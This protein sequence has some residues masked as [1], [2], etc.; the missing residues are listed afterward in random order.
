MTGS[1]SIAIGQGAQVS[2]IDSIGIGVSSNV[3][4]NN[5]GAFGD[6]NIVTG[7]GSYVVGNNNI[8]AANN[9]FVLGSFVIMTA[10]MTD[11][12][13]IGYGSSVTNANDVA[14]GARSATA[15]PHTGSYDITGGT[16]FATSDVNGVVSVGAPGLERQIQNVAAGVVSAS[17]SD[18]INGSQLYSVAT[19]GNLTGTTVANALGGGSTYSPATGVSAPSYTV[20]STPY[21][22][23][24]SAVTG[25]QTG[26]PVQYSTTTNPTVANGY[27]PS[28]NETLVGAAPG[29]VTLSNVAAGVAPTDAVNVSQLTSQN[30]TLIAA[31]LNFADATG[32]SVHENLGGTISVIGSTAPVGGVGAAF[33]SSGSATAGAYSAQNVQTVVNPATGQ[34]QVQIAANPNFTSV[35]TGNTVVNNAGVTVNGGTNGTVSLTNTGLNNGNN[36]ITNVAAG[37][38]QTDAVNV[39]QLDAVSTTASKGW[40]V[41]TAASGTGTVYGTSVANV[42]PGATQTVTAGNNIAITQ[43]GTGLTI[44]TN[45]NLVSTSLTTTD[46]TGNTT[47]TTGTG[48]TITDGTGNTTTTT[49]TGVTITPAGGGSPVSLT[50]TGLNNGNNTI[51]NVAAGVNQTDAV[52]V[53]QL[54]AVSTTASKGWNVT[55]AASGTGTVY[56]TSVANVAPGATQ[57][58]TAGNNIAITQNGTG[59]TIATN[60]NL[61]STS[62]TIQGGNSGIGIDMSN[63]KMTALAAGTISATSTDAVNGSQLVVLGANIAS[64]LGGASTVNP[65]TGVVTAAITLNGAAATAA[66]YNNVQSAINGAGFN[67][68]TGTVAGSINSVATQTTASGF[69]STGNS[70]TFQAGNNITIA[71]DGTKVAVAVSPNISLTSVTT[72]DTVGNKTVTNGSG[73]T[74]TPA[75]G[76]APVSLTTTGLNN[77]GNTITNV[78]PGVNGTDAVNVNQLNAGVSA[79][80]YDLG[81][82][83]QEERGGTASAMA[84]AQLPQATAPGEAMVSMGVSN[85]LGQ[86]GIAFGLS[87]VSDNGRIIFKAAGTINSAGQ[88][89]GSAGVGIHF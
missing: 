43:N 36:T 13:A 68:A 42:A 89:G 10:A 21:N 74:I 30:N 85:W 53:S 7:A 29:A 18:A 3:L 32:A 79:L 9:A 46:G 31:G 15:A 61:V 6:P 66:P 69:V 82:V 57:T 55:T 37:V 20:G 88:G 76:G 24:G 54:D 77:G 2:G 87:K 62:L 75:G 51:T 19:A 41:T 4:G 58:V 34:L 38:N 22:N 39:S 83:Q 14:L 80:T 12:V 35:T 48:V 60:P 84:M 56:G 23:V 52:N 70:A 1:G 64:T 50:T 59:L 28:Q 78:A 45:P 81:K 33:D 5:S 67:V 16:A 25:L 26:A 65:L 71:Q 86:Q 17:S 49:S 8:V 47:T 44:A 72:T 27:V 11:A 40:N 63:T 73:V